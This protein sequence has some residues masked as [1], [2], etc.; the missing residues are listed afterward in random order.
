MPITDTKGYLAGRSPMTTDN[1]NPK[2]PVGAGSG[3][4]GDNDNRFI[5]ALAM[6]GANPPQRII[7][8]VCY[9]II[10]LGLAILAAPPYETIKQLGALGLLLVA[11]LAVAIL[12]I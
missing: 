3:A 7:V 9:G 6:K 8:Y 12:V 5:A 1:S 10:A 2:D 4:G 11:L